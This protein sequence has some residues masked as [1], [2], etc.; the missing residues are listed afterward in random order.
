MKSLLLLIACI[1]ACSIH[2]FT[3]TGSNVNIASLGGSLMTKN[4]SENSSVTKP[5]GTVITYNSVGKDETAV[6]NKFISVAGNTGLLKATT[7]RIMPVKT[8]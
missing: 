3:Y 7:S 6:P 1:P 8:N 5:D 2:P 4:V